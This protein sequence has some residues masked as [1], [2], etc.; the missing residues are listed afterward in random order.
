MPGSKKHLWRTCPDEKLRV[1]LV[2]PKIRR[3]VLRGYREKRCRGFT[4]TVSRKFKPL[5]TFDHTPIEPKSFKRKTS[6]RAAL[7][8]ARMKL[9]PCI[10]FG[11]GARVPNLM[12][13]EPAFAR[14]I[15]SCAHM[16]EAFR[17]VGVGIDHAAQSPLGCFSPEPP[18]HIEAPR[19]R[20]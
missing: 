10:D 15:D 13:R 7:R 8:S 1:N 5:I 17:I 20:I 3:I 14:D 9:Q 19:A 11:Q 16:S 4:G 18:I 12:L 2:C 6:I